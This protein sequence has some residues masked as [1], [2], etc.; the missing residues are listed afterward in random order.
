MKKL[1]LSLLLLSSY[2]AFAVKEFYQIKR[3]VRAMGMGGAFYGLSD[4]EGALQYNPAG[5]SRIRS[6]GRFTLL[7]VKADL[8]PSIFDA[9]NT[10]SSGGGKDVQ[11]IAET[12]VQYQGKPVFGG[13]GLDFLGY[14]GKNFGIGLML[15]DT[16]VNFAILGKDL[17]TNLEATVIS[18][19]GLFAGY[20]HSFLED[21]L[22]VGLSLKALLRGGGRKA[23]TLLE[24]AQGNSFQIDPSKIGGTGF[25]IDADLG[26]TYQLPLE[27]MG[28]LLQS[29][30]SLVFNNLIASKFNLVT[31]NGTAPPGLVRTV[32]VGGH[33]IFAGWGP[34]DNF[35]ALIDFAEFSLGGE[36]NIDL[37]DRGGSFWKHVNLGVEAPMNGWFSP[38]LGI[39]QGYLTAGFGVN[40]RVAQIDFATYVEELGRGVGR[41]GTRRFT[42]RLALGWGGAPPAPLTGTKYEIPVEDEKRAL[43]PMEQE[44]QKRDPKSQ[45]ATVD[46]LAKPA[47][48]TPAAQPADAVQAQPAERTPQSGGAVEP[49]PDATTSTAP[50]GETVTIPK[51]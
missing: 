37:G 23:F 39:H 12:L 48:E 2:P 21:K 38:R 26:A 46:P 40:A 47:T 24:I 22:H 17:D 42:L 50:A 49:V 11:T 3:S 44:Q 10:I 51:D 27:Q 6:G 45:E 4:D 18:D 14:V 34:F 41:L 31:I 9:L 7:G 35:H 16:K 19:S 5:L 15:N 30:V 20:S 36:T 33:A 13:L 1:L 8:T 28:P 43:T 29:H 25:G 32:T